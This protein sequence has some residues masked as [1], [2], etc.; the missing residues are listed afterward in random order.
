MI[1]AIRN[2]YDGFWADDQY[3]AAMAPVPPEWYVP[4]GTYRGYQHAGGS[5]YRWQDRGVKSSNFGEIREAIMPAILI[6]ML[7]HDD[8]KFYP[9]HVFAMDQI[10]QASV[11]WGMYE[12]VCNYFGV[13]PKP[14]TAATTVSS[15]FPTLVG[16]NAAINGTVTMQNEGMAWCWGNKTSTAAWPV[17]IYFPYTVWKL[18]ATANEQ[19]A[20]GTQIP[21]AAD[22]VIYPGETAAFDIA[23]TGPATTGLYTT[24]WRMIKDDAFGGAFGDVITA[25]IQVDA[26]PPVITITSPAAQDYDYGC[27]DVAFSATDAL[28][29]VASLTAEIDGV[30]VTDGEKVCWL[31]LGSHTLTV[32]AVDTFGNAASQSVTFNMVNTVGKTTA[33]GW[34]ELA[35]KKATCGFVS[36]YIEGAPAPTG[37]VTY[38]DHDTGMTVN[39]VDLVAMGIVGNH[40]WIYGTC[41]IEGEAG[42]WFR[43]DVIDNGEPGST[44]QF[45]IKL[46]TGYAQGGVLGG[47]NITI[48]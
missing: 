28:S 30:A 46:D 35:S 24:E 1:N 22:A 48:H 39:S 21:I 17:S 6:E 18:A 9:D 10:F 26:D 36:E 14:R 15:S 29:A 38:Q 47:G 7:F 4:Y 37:N 5:A 25:Q 8:W 13:T 3:N 27:I 44:D 31:D 45:F 19:I 34:V 11:S 42:H 41:T 23:M 32:T 33:G 20:P 16:P 2:R 12:G 40:A 43:I